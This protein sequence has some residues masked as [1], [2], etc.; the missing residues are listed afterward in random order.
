MA[1]LYGRD[2]Q[3]LRF[4]CIKEARKLL[5]TKS[6]SEDVVEIAESYFEFITGHKEKKDESS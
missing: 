6:S 1:F 5:G 3:E 2:T 4:K